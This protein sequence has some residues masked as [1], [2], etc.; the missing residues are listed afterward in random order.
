M[1]NL[2]N[3]VLYYTF[4]SISIGQLFA[5]YLPNIYKHLVANTTFSRYTIET[6]ENTIL[7]LNV[8]VIFPNYDIYTTKGRDRFH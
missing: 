8:L 7:I 4:V 5:Q 6:R 2:S 1:S 3:P